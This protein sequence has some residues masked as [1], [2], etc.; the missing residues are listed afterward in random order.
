M[1]AGSYYSH[2]EIGQLSEAFD[3]MLEELQKREGEARN[4]EAR[5]RIL[6]EQSPNG[7][8]LVDTETG[9]TVE[10]NETAYQQLGY[11]RDEFAELRI[12]DYEVE[13]NPE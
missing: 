1:L 5:Y 3:K 12:S 10:A 13:E 4:A 6:F 2:G 11:T 9:K 7:I 8:V